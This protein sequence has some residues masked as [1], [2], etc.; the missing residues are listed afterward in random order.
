MVVR[1]SKTAF[2]LRDKLNQLNP[3]VGSHGSQLMKSADAEESFDLVRAGRKNIIQNGDQKIWQRYTTRQSAAGT[4]LIFISDRWM[5]EEGCS[6]LVATVSRSTDTPGGEGFQYS[7][8]I[9]VDTVESTITSGDFAQYMYFVEGYD[10]AHLE[11]GTAYAKP[12]TLSFWF[13]TTV[14]GHHYVSINSNGG[15]DTWSTRIHSPTNTWKKHVVKIDPPTSGTWLDDN[16]RGIEIRIGLCASP[17]VHQSTWN[18]WYHGGNAYNGFATANS[19]LVFTQNNKAWLTGV[20]LEVGTVATPFEFR[21]YGEE[22]RLCQ[23][24]YEGMIMGSGTA[25]LR[26]F[27]NTAGSPTNVSNVNHKYFVEKRATPNWR[28]EGNATWH[29]TGTSA[30]T[31]YPSKTE[32]LFQRNDTTHQFLTDGAGD[33]CGSF[34]AEFVAES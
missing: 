20:Q 7:A 31:A 9:N 3:P 2:N 16:R 32:C 4:G 13:K 25:L 10:M 15:T 18:K 1:V 5:F 24:Y 29:P 8:Q 14:A 30:M 33:L 34:S 22:L 21:S 11:W 19:N 12:A 23:R 27:T 6:Q 17:S 26:T 28:L